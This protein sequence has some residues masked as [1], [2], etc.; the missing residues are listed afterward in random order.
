MQHHKAIFI[1]DIH[2]GSQYS[3]AE[4]L[5]S[6][7]ESISWDHLYLVGDF[8]DFW[9]INSRRCYWD[10]H[11]TR[12]IQILLDRVGKG[13]KVTYCVGNHDGIIRQFKHMFPIELSNITVCDQIIHT[14]QAGKNYLVM[15]GDQFE[16]FPQWATPFIKIADYGY[17]FLLWLGK[18]IKQ[19]DDRKKVTI[20]KQAKKIAKKWV[21]K[22]FKIDRKIIKECITKKVDGIILGHT[23]DPIE[24]FYKK[25]HILNDGDWVEHNTAIIEQQDGSLKTIYWTESKQT[26]RDEQIEEGNNCNPHIQ[27]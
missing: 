13:Q 27:R 20:S 6:F 9:T 15:H 3:S 1:S 25:I 2:L 11:H 12:V 19:S 17:H 10:E 16:Q 23:H 18:L 7:L 5:C 21:K 8:L 14:T 4:Q 22:L 24:K 26:N